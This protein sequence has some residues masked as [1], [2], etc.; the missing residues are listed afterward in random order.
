MTRNIGLLGN[1]NNTEQHFKQTLNEYLESKAKHYFKTL[2]L[3]AQKRHV[4]EYAVPTLDFIELEFPGKNEVVIL[5]RRSFAD[6]IF[7]LHCPCWR[8]S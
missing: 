5:W 8:V 1:S 4:T 2:D 7:A 3:K 6:S